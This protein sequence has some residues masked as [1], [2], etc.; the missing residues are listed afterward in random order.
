MLSTSQFIV[1]YM[2][3][4]FQPM[5]FVYM[6]AA[7]FNFKYY[8]IMEDK[9]TMNMIMKRLKKEVAMTAVY[10][11]QNRETP[12]GY[13]VGWK[14]A[15]YIEHSYDDHKM[16]LLAKPSFYKLLKE[17]PEMRSVHAEVKSVE[18]KAVTRKI[19]V[20]IRKG[21]YQNFFY[22]RVKLDLS[23]VVPM[24]DQTKIV[25]DIVTLYDRMGRCTIFID[26]VTNAGKSTIGYLVAKELRGS[27][28]HTFNPTE[29][30]D[31]I[32]NATLDNIFD[33]SPMIIVLEEVDQMLKNVHVGSVQLNAKTPTSIY[34]KTTW[35]S[36]LDDMIFYKRVILIMTSNADRAALDALDPSYLRPGRVDAYFCMPNPL[37]ERRD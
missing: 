29:P 8:I 15:G 18:Q 25:N 13:F 33:E 1:G 5:L 6:I 7:C 17:T 3:Y 4:Y 30:G 22:N 16:Y 26:G 14:C 20:F 34:N 28:C 19:D 32:S 2:G 37:S 31:H 23:H 24:G 10:S 36:F 9:E 35:C 27:Y 11:V 12:G 21:S